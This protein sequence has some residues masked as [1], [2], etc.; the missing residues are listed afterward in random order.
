MLVIHFLVGFILTGSVIFGSALAIID[1][2]LGALI[3][4]Y[5]DRFWSTKVQ[6]GK[7]EE[8]IES[9]LDPECDWDLDCE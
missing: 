6:F 4:Y 2:V 7:E 8:S 1:L 5:H 3:F 9:E